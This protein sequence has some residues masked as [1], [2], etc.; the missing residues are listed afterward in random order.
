MDFRISQEQSLVFA[1][2]EENAQAD[3]SLILQEREREIE[4]VSDNIVQVVELLQSMHSTVIEQGTLLDQIDYNL[5][6]ASH[7]VSQ[8]ALHIGQR[9]ERQKNQS[10]RHITLLIITLLILAL[11]VAIAIRLKA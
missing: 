7:L 6:E 8:A 3:C 2:P 11:F 1:D 5:D 4:K 10:F 9:S